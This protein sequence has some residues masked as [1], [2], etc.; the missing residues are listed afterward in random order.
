LSYRPVDTTDYLWAL[1]RQIDRVAELATAYFNDAS[2]KPAPYRAKAF[3]GSVLVLYAMA[4]PV[5]EEAGAVDVRALHANYAELATILNG[6]HRVAAAKAL[7]AWEE[8][9]RALYLSRLLFRVGGSP[10]EV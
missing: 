10:M 3:A 8:I 2:R 4:L 1:T 6:D 5:L 7:Q 9:L